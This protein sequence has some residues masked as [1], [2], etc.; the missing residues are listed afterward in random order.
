[1]PPC[2]RWQAILAETG[3]QQRFMDMLCNSAVAAYGACGGEIYCR[4]GCSCC[5]T[6]AVNC[7]AAEA[8]LVAAV[9]AKQ[10][11]NALAV[12]VEKLKERLA[13][14]TGLKEYLHMHR[15][16]LDGCPFL[17]AGVC[18]VYPARPISCRAL[19]STRESYWCGADFSKL[20]AGEKEAFLNSLDRAFTSFP[21]HYL[22][23]TRD[24]GQQL[25]AQP[26]MLM[27]KEFG[28]SLYGSL[29]VMVHL[30]SK[31]HLLAALEK[32]ADAVLKLAASAGL[33]SPYLLQIEKL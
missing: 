12:Y 17:T 20:A 27:V 19:L 29:P 16:E 31:H 26:T 4:K 25:E 30:F 14:V 28:F 8:F 21:L 2:E 24:A 22:A 10:Q 6:L 32:G 18:G 3:R 9:I 23:S 15:Q 13:G 33:D 7:T 1:M 11:M 5:C